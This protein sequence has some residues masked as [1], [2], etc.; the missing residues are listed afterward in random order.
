VVET[1]RMLRHLALSRV[2]VVQVPNA[3]TLE[4]STRVSLILPAMTPAH[5]TA[6]P[7]GVMLRPTVCFHANHQATAPR[8]LI[9]SPILLVTRRKHSCVVQ[10]LMMHLH[11]NVLVRCVILSSCSHVQLF[12][13]FSDC[14]RFPW[15]N[16]SLSVWIV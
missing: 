3:L 4:S 13:S 11:A 7:P 8:I 15:N 1:L 10:V 9:V 2:P 12:Y 6:V 16:S 5:T 14:I